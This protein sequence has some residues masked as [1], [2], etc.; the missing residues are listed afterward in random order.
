MAVGFISDKLGDYKI[1]TIFG[2]ILA[3]AG[4]FGILWLHYDHPSSRQYIGSTD[5][6]TLIYSLELKHATEQSYTFPLLMA[7]LLLGL[8]S[9]TSNDTLLEAI[10]LVI[11]KTH[12]ADFARQKLWGKV[13]KNTALET[14]FIIF[15]FGKIQFSDGITL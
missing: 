1:L 10:G 4:P 8:Y 11:S 7:F 15:C 9:A 14:H 2:V 13:I 5:N 3:G 6:S 12:G